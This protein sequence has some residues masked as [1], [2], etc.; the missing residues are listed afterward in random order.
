MCISF[1]L[2]LSLFLTHRKFWHCATYVFALNSIKF[3]LFL[4]STSSQ[5]LDYIAKALSYFTKHKRRQKEREREKKLK[6]D[7]TFIWI[8][9]MRH[10]RENFHKIY[11]CNMRV[12][13]EEEGNCCEIN[14]KN[15]FS[16]SLLIIHVTLYYRIENSSMRLLHSWAR[17]QQ[18][19]TAKAISQ[20]TPLKKSGK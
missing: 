4:S 3:S 16:K 19:Q 13:E 11:F 1:A 6:I 2:S 14:G 8:I 17:R 20:A 10:E 9:C 18:Q 7:E 12:N 5:L 15:D